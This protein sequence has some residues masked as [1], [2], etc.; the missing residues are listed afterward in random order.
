MVR[1]DNY[2]RTH[3]CTTCGEPVYRCERCRGTGQQPAGAYWQ[4]SVE[5]YVAEPSGRCNDCGGLGVYQHTKAFHA[6][7]EE[8]EDVRVQVGRS[9]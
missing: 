7:N 1:T 8:R 3:L 4:I 5:A 6:M 2:G 9:R